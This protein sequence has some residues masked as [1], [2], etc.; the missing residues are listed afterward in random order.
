MPAFSAND[1]HENRL[2]FLHIMKTAGTT[3]E[4]ILKRQ[5][6]DLGAIR[7]YPKKLE[8]N[9]REFNELSSAEQN[10][11]NV[12]MGHFRFGLHRELTGDYKYITLMRNPVDRIMSE[13]YYILTH[14]EHE[15]HEPMTS[16]YK[17]IADFVRSG[18]Y[19]LL[20]NTH[21][22]YLSGMDDLGYG[23][24]SSEAVEIAR[25]NLQKH[26]SFVG[27]T[28]EFDESLIFLKRMYNWSTPYYIRENV[29]N[30]RPKTESLTP[31]ERAVIEEYA[32]MDIE[33]YE[34]IRSE[35]EERLSQQ[36]GTFRN[37]VEAFK[38]LNGQ[39]VKYFEMAIRVPGDLYLA[40]YQHV[41][42]VFN[43]L[44]KDQHLNEAKTVL[45]YAIAQ[46]PDAGELIAIAEMLKEHIDNKNRLSKLQRTERLDVDSAMLENVLDEPR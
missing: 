14:P 5:Y 28:E 1:D 44:L 29:T 13:Y 45:S 24:Y 41:L 36:D 15:L 6:G 31:E 4:R 21:T 37:E 40:Q 42:G 16:Q 38:L 3:L 7:F 27:I 10:K 22:K 17:N 26:F 2:I 39:C 34:H 35:F 18:M 9:L 33:L 43:N 23:E 30:N 32:R 25:E 11:V 46:F 20:D 12:I 19:H 8:D